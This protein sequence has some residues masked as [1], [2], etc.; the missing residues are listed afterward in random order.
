MSQ[1]DAYQVQPSH[2]PP[3]YGQPPAYRQYAPPGAGYGGAAR[4]WDGPGPALSVPSGLA[5]A[6]VVLAVAVTAVQVL[7]W[8]T[9]FGAVERYT[10]A[11]SVGVPSAEV[12]TA[13]DTVATLL[14]LV[15]LAAG[16]V[17][18]VWLWSSRSIAEAVAPE[19][20]HAR[21]RVWVWLGWIVPVVSLWFPYQV[22]RDVRAATVA[23]PRPGL[24][25]W[26]TGWL[27]F[28][29]ATNVAAQVASSGPAASPEVYSVLP[30]AESV[31][32]AAVVLALVL[33]ARIVREVTAG[34]RA[35]LT[36]SPR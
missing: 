21:S 34:Q 11:A 35:V 10:Q 13:Y 15:Q 29:V 26:W 18:C 33:W 22:V 17:T 8:L 12:F 5:T 3:A 4:P 30:V 23:S 16:V 24:G 27:V 25:W 28:G 32:T 14:L 20:G 7:S 1:H 19:R 6:T 2:Q 31:G 36:T 9:S